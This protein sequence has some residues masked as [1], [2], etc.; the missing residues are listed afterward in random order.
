MQK[1]ERSISGAK[2]NFRRGEWLRGLGLGSQA[3]G[4]GFESTRSQICRLELNDRPLVRLSTKEKSGKYQ[5]RY[6][7]HTPPIFAEI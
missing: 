4:R 7:S 3:G 6:R 5:I 2:V 1:M